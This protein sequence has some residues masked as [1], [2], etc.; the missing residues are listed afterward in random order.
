M[1]PAPE[2]YEIETPMIDGRP[3][4]HGQSNVVRLPHADEPQDSF[5]SVFI[6]TFAECDAWLE[7]HPE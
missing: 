6:G 7:A 4:W 3:D 2:H 1:S 5:V